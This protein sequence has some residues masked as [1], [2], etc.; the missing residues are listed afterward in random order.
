MYRAPLRETR[1]VLEELL[2]TDQLTNSP[3]LADYSAELGQ[4]V[5][6]EAANSLKRSWSR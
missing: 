5:L 2:G 4:S 6:E 1:F 3:H